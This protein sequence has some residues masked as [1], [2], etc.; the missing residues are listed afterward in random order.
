[1]QILC[2]QIKTVFRYYG[3]HK[4]TVHRKNTGKFHG[5]SLTGLNSF[6]HVGNCQE[7]GTDAARVGTAAQTERQQ[8]RAVHQAGPRLAP[9]H[10]GVHRGFPRQI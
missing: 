1:V 4:S 9:V 5:V 7:L 6:I 8:R 2:F 3:S 10:Q